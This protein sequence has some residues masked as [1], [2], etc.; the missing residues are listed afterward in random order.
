MV[1]YFI[2][3]ILIRGLPAVTWSFLTTAPNPIKKTIGIFPSIVNTLYIIVFTLIICVPI[4]VGGAIYLNEYAKNKKFVRVIEFAT[5]TLSGIP[6]ILYGVFG[7]VVF[8]LMFGLKVSLLAGIFTLTIMVLPIMI[9]TSQEALRSVP[10]SYRE[11][12]LGMGATKWYMVRTILLPS[13]L[14]GILTGI[15]LSIGRMVSESA[16][17]LLVAGGS[18][19]YMPKGSIL[20]QLSGS[21]STLSV[22]LYR[23][24]YSRGDNQTAF[25]IAAV[26]IIIVILLNLLTRY[27]AERLNKK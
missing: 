14:G 17:L 18:A 5:E 20:D 6:S 13:S 21:G 4:G 2:A 25:G 7:Y 12:A 1:I 16:A 19:M 3:V 15:I 22:E 10:K 23:Y 26:L 11:G 27:I 9:R 24:A 8:C